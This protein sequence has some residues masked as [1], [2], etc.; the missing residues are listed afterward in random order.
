MQAKE[1]ISIP[2]SM[3]VKEVREVK[4]VE[5]IRKINE[6]QTK[7]VK[8]LKD[9]V[10]K[11]ISETE[12]MVKRFSSH[13]NLRGM[14]T[15]TAVDTDEFMGRKKRRDPAQELQKTYGPRARFMAGKIKTISKIDERIKKVSS[16]ILPDPFG[17]PHKGP[18]GPFTTEQEAQKRQQ[19][20]F[21]HQK[22]VLEDARKKRFDALDEARK[23]VNVPVSDEKT[24]L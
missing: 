5:E 16:K 11:I 13:P 1:E 14:P 18:M 6:E 7:K 20:K 15:L 23:S 24:Q 19:D 4:A 9:S 22:K 12:Q 2:K 21:K 8:Q 10:P 17:V 3:Q